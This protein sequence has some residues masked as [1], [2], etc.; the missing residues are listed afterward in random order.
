MFGQINSRFIKTFRSSAW[1]KRDT[2][3]RYG[4]AIVCQHSIP[5]KSQIYLTGELI[6]YAYGVGS[7][8][9][10]HCP[11]L[12]Y[13]NSVFVTCFIMN[14]RSGTNGRLLYQSGNLGHPIHCYIVC[15]SSLIRIRSRMASDSLTPIIPFAWMSCYQLHQCHS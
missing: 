15:A 7:G 12:S 14:W 6:L 9:I 11:G 8:P 10:A 2:N 1:H 4:H 3:N 5:C 13:H